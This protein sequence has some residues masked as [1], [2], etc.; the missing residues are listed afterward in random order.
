ML[1]VDRRS[2]RVPAG[3]RRR[4]VHARVTTLEGP[5]DNLDRAAQHV[6]EQLLPQLREQE[7]FKG[8]IA[9]GD[10]Q[11]GK[12]LGVV[13]WESEDALRTSEEAASRMRD[14]SAEAIGDTIG[15]VE[16]YEVT[17]FEVPS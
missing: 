1:V 11:S 15:G 7:G 9:L 10:R 8:F 17:V 3:E 4:G 12:L 6:R 16:R 13:L 14:E 5:P 2:S